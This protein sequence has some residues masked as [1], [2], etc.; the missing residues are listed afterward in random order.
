MGAWSHEPFGNDDAGDW[1][2]ELEG[3]TDFSAIES[4]LAAV[5]SEAGGYLEAPECSAALAAAEI[6]AALAGKPITSLP[7]DAAAWVSGK[8]APVVAL[9]AQA[10]SA[11]TAVL[12]S[13]ELQELWEDSD[14][15]A[16]WQAITKDLLKR[17]S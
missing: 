12:E 8:G 17:L 9:I 7:D 14:D 2:Y 3:S 16:A 15:Y 4:A 1:L 13:S 6:V 10:R 11:V 5:T